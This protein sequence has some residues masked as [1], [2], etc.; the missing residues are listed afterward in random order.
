M[1]SDEQLSFVREV[2]GDE[3][4]VDISVGCD[5]PNRRPVEPDR[6]ELLPSRSQDGR[7]GDIGITRSTS[8]RSGVHW[9]STT[10]VSSSVAGTSRHSDSMAALVNSWR[11]SSTGS[12]STLTVVPAREIRR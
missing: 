6:S 12:A 9:S 8:G 2:V 10:I 5:G 11:I 3:S 4:R 7:S 1:C